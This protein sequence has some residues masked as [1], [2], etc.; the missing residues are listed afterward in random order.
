[1]GFNEAAGIH[2]RK[3][4][5]SI[6]KK[7]TS[8]PASMRPPEFTGGNATSHRDCAIGWQASMRPPEFTGGKPVESAR[9][10][11]KRGL[12]FNEAA[13]IH[14]RKPAAQGLQQLLARPASMRPPEFTGGNMSI[15]SRIIVAGYSCFNEA[16]GIHRRKR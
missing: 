11:V 1:M 2:P 16:A 5:N 7:C 10:S 15:A 13:G 4:V 12:R 14:R 6:C 9:G 8:F 3:Q